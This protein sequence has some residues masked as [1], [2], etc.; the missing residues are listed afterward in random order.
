MKKI[1]ALFLM[2]CALALTMAFTLN[3]SNNTIQ[4]SLNHSFTQSPIQEL[5][6]THRPLPMPLGGYEVGDKV[7]DFK[8]PGVDGLQYSLSTF[9]EV[10]G[11][12]IIFTC[13][14]CPVAQ[15]YEQRIMALQNGY[16]KVGFPVIAIN[17]NNPLAV[18]GDSMDEMK[19][20]SKEKKYPFVYLSDADAKVCNQFGA[21]NTPHVYLLDK[22]RVV[23]YIG[24][25]DD[26]AD[27]ATAVKNR[28]LENAIMA[29]KSG[30][31]PEPSMTKA[32]GC[33]IKKRGMEP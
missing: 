25:I 18:S 22:N 1:M 15:K 2:P 10:E 17:S 33:S 11:Y 3:T 29:V 13:N 23:K 14:T 6:I 7:E 19:K 31:N 9:K 5:P 30:K 4:K 8:L 21:S 32:F 12:V 20:R 28:Y 26:N 24:A 16:F 27:D